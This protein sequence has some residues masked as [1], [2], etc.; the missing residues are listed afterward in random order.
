MTASTPK[1][2][3]SSIVEDCVYFWKTDTRIPA[4]RARE[5]GEELEQHLWDAM[6]DGKT[7]ESVVGPDVEA[8][9][10][11]WADEERPSTSTRDRITETVFA[12]S[13]FFTLTA[14]FFHLLDWTLY[15]PILWFPLLFFIGIASWLVRQTIGLTSQPQTGSL[16]KN[17]AFDRGRDIVGCWIGGGG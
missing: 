17:W 16:R 3:L 6:E 10:E 5:M 4:D 2:R 11:S 1:R 7:V 13:A 8:F 12:I 14:A 15:V 9:A